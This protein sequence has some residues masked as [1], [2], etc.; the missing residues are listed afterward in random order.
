MLILI[1]FV[2]SSQ[3]RGNAQSSNEYDGLC[4]TKA[5][6]GLPVRAESQDEPAVCAIP[7]NMLSVVQ[8]TQR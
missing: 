5:K 4:R 6:K 8:V 3:D 1:E 7:A 2:G